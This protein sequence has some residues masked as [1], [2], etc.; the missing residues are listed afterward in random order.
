MKSLQ[1]EPLDS[2]LVTAS[3]VVGDRAW[4][5]RDA[6]SGAVLSAKREPRLLLAAATVAGEGVAVTIPRQRESLGSAADG[7]LS[8]WLG[9]AVRIEPATETPYVDEAHLH[10]L[11]GAELVGFRDTNRETRDSSVSAGVGLSPVAGARGSHA[12]HWLAS[13]V[14]GC[15][16]QVQSAESAP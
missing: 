11:A 14:Q 16:G 13:R 4:G 15:G 12:R 8:S 2:V 5:V 7:A 6:A 3:G 9:R 1:G 10:L